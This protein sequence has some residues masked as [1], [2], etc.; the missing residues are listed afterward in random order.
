MAARLATGARRALILLPLAAG[1][2]FGSL[3]A[4]ATLSWDRAFILWQLLWWSIVSIVVG[5]IYT[6]LAGVITSAIPRNIPDQDLWRALTIT[7]W[8]YRGGMLALL[9]GLSIS[10]WT[11]VTGDVASAPVEFYWPLP[12]AAFLFG[13]STMGDRWERDREQQRKQRCSDLTSAQKTEY[14]FA[15]LM[16][17]HEL[18]KF[19]RATADK[20][21]RATAL[22][23]IMSEQKNECSPEL[24][25]GAL[26][27]WT[28]R[29]FIT[30]EIRSQ[31]DDSTLTRLREWLDYGPVATY[32]QQEVVRLLDAGQIVCDR[33]KAVGMEAALLEHDRCLQ[34]SDQEKA[35]YRAKLLLDIDDLSPHHD[36]DAYFN[37]VSVVKLLSSQE[38]PWPELAYPALQTLSRFGLIQIQIEYGR[39]V[40]LGSRVWLTQAGQEIC[41]RVSQLGTV[42]AAITERDQRHKRCLE[43]TSLQRVEFEDQFLLALYFTTDG[44]TG[45]VTLGDVW[46]RLNHECA[47]EL[48]GHALKVWCERK[49]IDIDSPYSIQ[50]LQALSLSAAGRD[51]CMRAIILGTMQ[52]ALSERSEG[53]RV[54]N[55]YHIQAAN[56]VG[57][58]A[59]VH[60]NEFAQFVNTIDRLQLDK[61]A[62]EL[63]TLRNELVKVA[64]SAEDHIA[65]GDVPAAEVG[66][67]IGGVSAAEVAARNGDAQG[68]WQHL[69]KVG[70]WVLDAAKQIGTP[71]AVEA[72]NAVFKAYKIPIS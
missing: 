23:R 46:D 60:D 31:R 19:P 67:A 59:H 10:I 7:R 16:K 14:E 51:L 12:I 20:F 42:E 26:Q 15:F 72:I 44:D 18:D 33:A 64:T 32:T 66:I 63:A 37:S 55:E 17:L 28:N 3:L 2:T 57:T 56:V 48:T 6:R 11:M 25:L 34:L 27:T 4:A 62:Q 52:E 8:L 30:V 41:K 50:P 61:L 1:L 70:R 35:E 39:S 36:S 22:R 29:K 13:L 58:N 54:K 24:W 5:I 21:P 38:H 68:V 47:P 49:D 53:Y 9:A 40:E 43:A 65:I 69:A 71:V 45:L